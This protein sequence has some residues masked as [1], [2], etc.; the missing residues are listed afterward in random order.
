MSRSDPGKLVAKRVH[1][2]VESRGEQRTNDEYFARVFAYIASRG[3]CTILSHA[4]KFLDNGHVL[5][6]RGPIFHFRMFEE[7]HR[8]DLTERRYSRD[9]DRRARSKYLAQTSVSFSH[10]S[11][12][13]VPPAIFVFPGV[14][15]RRLARRM[16][17]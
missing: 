4:K 6:N 3:R 12:I 1:G 2:F 17:K 7:T 5:V 9:G 14:H 16:Y 15:R 13:C 11:R 8:R 10:A